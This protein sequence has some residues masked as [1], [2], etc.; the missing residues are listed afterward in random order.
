MPSNL[1]RRAVSRLRPWFGGGPKLM[2]SWRFRY[3]SAVPGARERCL[4]I[5]INLRL[6]TNGFQR[7]K[8]M[9]EK[10]IAITRRRVHQ[11]QRCG[12][13]SLPVRRRRLCVRGGGGGQG[14]R[15]VATLC[16]LHAHRHF[17]GQDMPALSGSPRALPS[18]QLKSILKISRPPSCAAYMS[19]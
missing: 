12:D 14:N 4:S 10:E 11:C 1:R 5:G 7:I 13:Q 8:K 16:A 3:R 19:L 2:W 17:C 18:N 15:P 9:A 6:I